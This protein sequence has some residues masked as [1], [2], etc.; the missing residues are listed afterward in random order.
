MKGYLETIPFLYLIGG[1]DSYEQE[2]DQLALV[3]MARSGYQPNAAVSL[4]S[5]LLDTRS[6][7]NNQHYRPNSLKERLDRVKAGVQLF[8]RSGIDFVVY[9]DRLRQIKSLLDH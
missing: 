3:F 6:E 8:Q 9:P 2:A 5:R 1:K 7:S 4:L